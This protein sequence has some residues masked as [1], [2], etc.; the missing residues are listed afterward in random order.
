MKP[1]GT[2]TKYYP[3]IDEETQSILDIL[4]KESSSYNDFVQKLCDVVITN[5]IP[6]NL[7][8]ISAV[9]A[10]WCRK[11]ET[12]S[13]IQ[14][15]YTDESRIRP[16]GYIHSS[17]LTDQERYHDAVVEAI[18]TALATSLEDWVAT[19]LHLLH[20]YFHFPVFG[21]NPSLIE[22]LEKSKILIDTNPLLRCFEPLV[23]PFEGW[24]Q[25]R[26]GN[27]QD[28]ISIYK[29]GRKLAETNNDSLFIYMNLNFLANTLRYLDNP[30]SIKLFED[31]F[32]LAQDLEVPYL[33]AEVLHDS[34]YTF[35]TAGEY[36]LAISCQHESIKIMG[37]GDTPY[38]ALAR[39]YATLGN[40][41][42]ALES[43]NQAFEYIGTVEFPTF[44]H[45]K[46][47]ALALMN[48]LEEAE[49]YLTTASS[50]V[51]KTGQELQ[52][53]RHYHVSGVVELARGDY[54]AALNN[55]EKSYEIIDRQHK[56]VYV[57]LTLLDLARAEI[58]LADH[59]T[60]STSSVAPGK[61]LA[62]LEKNALER[63][64]I[65][66]RM[67]AA[68]L[69]SEFYEKHGQLK[70][71]HATLMSALNLTDSLGVQTLRKKINERIR[72]LNQLLR[73]ADISS[74]K[75]NK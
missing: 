65:G 31:L 52:L 75:R 40:G 72:E 29:K 45:R 55:L 48:R 1:M 14:E 7:A 18:E 70:D 35:E 53:A 66:I 41:H 37:G 42:E 46:A 15:K 20:A 16:W 9:Q 25:M 39:I 2:I 44:Y 17:T 27:T 12:M 5:E 4:M 10:W 63:N 26:D 50:L 51:L 68:L 11:E 8:Y 49:R 67:Y 62:M 54:L 47:W 22:P 23:C 13:L 57:N 33:M 24:A 32:T 6:T 60:D 34:A 73:E 38:L 59:S 69:K 36:D 74:E 61:W 3:F 64:F 19:E 21:D 71:A 28:S 30:E 58:L 56:G 43:I